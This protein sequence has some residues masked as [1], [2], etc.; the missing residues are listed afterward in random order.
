MQLSATCRT[1]NSKRIHSSSIAYTTHALKRR[2]CQTAPATP[3]PSHC[4]FTCCAGPAAASSVFEGVASS[5]RWFGFDTESCGLD[6]ERHEV[7]SIAAHDLES[8]D[9]Y[10]ALIN[11]ALHNP[12]YAFGAEAYHGGCQP[13]CG[14]RL[15][16]L[17]ASIHLPHVQQ[18]W[19]MRATR[20]R[21]EV[22]FLDNLLVEQGAHIRCAA[23]GAL[24]IQQNKMLGDS[25]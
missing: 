20:K 8:G 14:D 1:A 21:K 5:W 19:W 16:T 10:T 22:S 12:K 2:L 11:P 7:I 3:Q 4:S 6:V 24:A 15:S 25:G 18:L 9:S 13:L 23:H 17:Q